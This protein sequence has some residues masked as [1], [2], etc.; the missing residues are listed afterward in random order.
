MT[1]EQ[2]AKLCHE[3][4]KQYCLLLGDDSQKSWE[5]APEWQRKSAIGGVRFHIEHKD[6]DPCD[7]HNEWLRIKLADGWSYGVVKDVSKREHPCCVPY[8]DL[9]VEQK[10][11]DSLFM[12]IV[13]L[14]LPLLNEEGK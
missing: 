4:N 10:I 3:T 6:A 5:D 9:P 13:A 12:S 11:K 14:M 2:I 7:S 1:V 8:E